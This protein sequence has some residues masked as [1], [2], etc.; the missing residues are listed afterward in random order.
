MKPLTRHNLVLVI[1]LSIAL[2]THT[3][4]TSRLLQTTTRSQSLTSMCA[5]FSDRT[6]LVDSKSQTDAA[7]ATTA[8]KSSI[9]I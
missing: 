4:E 5:S 2:S 3:Y 7:S 9:K 8:M 6:T 1:L